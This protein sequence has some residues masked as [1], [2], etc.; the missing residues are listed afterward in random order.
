[1][2]PVVI[3]VIVLAV[4]AIAVVAILWGQAAAKRLGEPTPDKPELPSAREDDSSSAP[5]ASAADDSAEE[6]LSKTAEK[7]DDAETEV[8]LPQDGDLSEP[9]G[10]AESSAEAEK[11]SSA[12]KE[13]PAAPGV[14]LDE[15]AEDKAA[16]ELEKERKERKLK[17]LRS[18]L[19]PTRGG[20]I[21][22]L[23]GVFKSKK[24]LS[25]EI[26]EE[27]EEVLL[28]SD[29]GAK[30]ARKLLETIQE[31][32]EKDELSDADAAWALLREAV[33]Q[34]LS[35][36][37][38][39]LDIE[40]SKPFVVMVVGVNG[41]G[42]TTTIGKL[43]TKFSEHNKKIVLA[44]ADTFRAAAVNQLTIWGNRVGADVVK[45][46]EGADPS[47]VVFEAVKKAKETDADI[48][49]ADTAGRLHTQQPLMEEL[50]KIHR[51]MGKAHETA[52]HEVLLVLDATTGQNA[53][54]QVA[55]FKE[56]LN[57]TGLVLTKLDGTA[58]GGVIIGICHEHAIPVR[59]IGIGE[60]KDD[61]REFD[62]DD[63]VDALFLR[64]SD[65][66]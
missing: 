13:A 65:A 38:E 47:S 49:I 43:A 54:Q 17:R 30:T 44:A 46:K 33:R 23:G 8:S 55:M 66:E 50:K 62:V 25:P 29:V 60:S 41:V 27:L 6:A 24:E 56:T 51:V 40:K 31:A 3:L 42:K 7:I 39:Q 15:K 26:I 20:L 11:A 35:V 59:F 64:D 10:R 34:I 45:S 18:G 57:I 5:E 16:A 48:V 12:E 37:C 14:R 22:K 1:M 52:P 63:F 53:I 28:T 32:L 36:P 21:S 58:K 61:L 9:Q 19:A 2:I 4:A